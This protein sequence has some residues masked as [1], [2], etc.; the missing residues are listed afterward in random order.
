MIESFTLS[1]G[2]RVPKII[3]GTNGIDYETLKTI[4]L[5]AMQTG[6]IAFDTAPNYVSEK[7]L[8]KVIHELINDYGFKRED[9]FIQSKLDWNAQKDGK[10]LSAVQQSLRTLGIE[11][12]D[13]YL[14]HWPYHETFINDW[15]TMEKIYNDGLVRTIGVCNFRERHWLKLIDSNPSIIP[16]MSQIEI[17]PF[18]NC[19]SLL[20]YCTS[21]GVLSQAYTPLLKMKPKLRENKILLQLA[22]KHGTSVPHIVLK[23][24]IDRG[25]IPVTKSTKPHRVEENTKC[26]DI[27]LSPEDTTLINSLD[28]DYKFMLES[29]GCPGF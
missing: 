28:E 15:K 9:F 10:V 4:C 3:V 20:E 7:H 27:H 22:A 14:M 25:V 6:Q 29:W 12:L 24:H 2:V 16:H 17:H 1:N 26:L 11:Y 5:A 13:S 18:R 19:S 21:L 23:W 8:G